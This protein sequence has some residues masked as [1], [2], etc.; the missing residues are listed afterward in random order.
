ML[1]LPFTEWT[2]HPLILAAN[3]TGAGAATCESPLLAAERCIDLVLYLSE[4]IT[5]AAQ[6]ACPF[7]HDCPRLDKLSPAAP[8]WSTAPLPT[9]IAQQRSAL[10]AGSNA[11]NRRAR[12]HGGDHIGLFG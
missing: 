12:S 4:I 2:A 1:A 11:I 3:R 9:D 5:G 8:H 6:P 7:R 10:G